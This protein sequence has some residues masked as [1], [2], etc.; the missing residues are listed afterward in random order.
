MKTHEVINK[1][2]NFF[3]SRDYFQKESTTLI[4]PAFSSSFNLSGA[5]YD[6]NRIA[7]YSDELKKDEAWYMLDRTFRHS[8]IE[9]VG[10]GHHLSFFEMF[11]NVVGSPNKRASKERIIN[12]TFEILTKV[13]GLD[14][15]KIYI[16][17]FGGGYVKNDLHLKDEESYDL[18]KRAGI[19][20]KNLIWVNG[21]KNFIYLVEDGEQAGP[22][23]EIYFDVSEEDKGIELLEIGT[24]VFETHKFSSKQGKLVPIKNYVYGNAFGVERLSMV[25]EKL[26]NIFETD[27]LLPLVK[28]IESSISNKGVADVFK[29]DLYVVVDSFRS[30]MFAVMDGQLPDNSRRGQILKK[31]IKTLTTQVKLLYIEKE[32]ELYENLIKEICDIFGSRYP[33]LMSSKKD[34]LV[35]LQE[36]R[37]KG[38][39]KPDSTHIGNEWPV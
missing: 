18:W 9:K 28:K 37:K 26:N 11:T 13:L 5:H 3:E 6:V 24:T 23:C 2:S 20:E 35:L 7:N 15:Q 1:I 12:E 36:A 8:D 17:V 30:L 19:S 29:T 34:V 4:S 10:D 27:S 16:T 32:M 25:T 14:S 38:I 39:Y 22:R 31:I 21:H 33:K